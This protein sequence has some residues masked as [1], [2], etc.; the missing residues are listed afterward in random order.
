MSLLLRQATRAERRTTVA[1]SGQHHIGGVPPGSCK[2]EG[3]GSRSC[4]YI[5][6]SPFFRAA[7]ARTGHRRGDGPARS[8]QPNPRT[9]PSTHHGIPARRRP[10]TKTPATPTRPTQPAPKRHAS[11]RRS[12]GRLRTPGDHRSS[13]ARHR[14][15]GAGVGHRSPDKR[16]GQISAPFRPPANPPTTPEWAGEKSGRLVGGPS[17]GVIL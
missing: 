9:H 13:G 7:T 5:G 6:Q 10:R 1:H 3:A 14:N 15:P 11:T 17:C 4:P 12:G 2:K 8:T 16:S